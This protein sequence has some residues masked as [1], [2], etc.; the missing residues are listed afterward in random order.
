MKFEIHLV[1]K[2]KNMFIIFLFLCF[3]YIFFIKLIIKIIKILRVDAFINDEHA[4]HRGAKN[5]TT[6]ITKL[7]YSF[8]L[9]V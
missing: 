5:N 2:L 3:F 8:R 6:K 9:L 4:N 7:P 1:H